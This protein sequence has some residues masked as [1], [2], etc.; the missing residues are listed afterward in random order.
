MELSAQAQ[1]GPEMTLIEVTENVEQGKCLCKRGMQLDCR[2]LNSRRFGGSDEYGR[3]FTPEKVNI[4]IESVSH[5]FAIPFLCYVIPTH[6]QIKHHEALPF[7][8][9]CGPRAGPAKCQC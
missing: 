2:R 8:T 1:C 4:M 6:C 5:G 7:P 3:C 9:T